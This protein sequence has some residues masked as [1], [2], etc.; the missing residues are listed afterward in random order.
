MRRRKKDTDEKKKKA[1]TRK[2]EYWEKKNRGEEGKEMD[3]DMEEMVRGIGR[4]EE[5][6]RIEGDKR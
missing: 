6:E 3:K 1:R 5:K 4:E 2:M